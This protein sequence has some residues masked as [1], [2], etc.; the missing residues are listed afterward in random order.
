MTKIPEFQLY[1][2]NDPNIE[3]RIQPNFGLRRW[4]ELKKSEKEIALQELKNRGWIDLDSREILKTIEYLNFHFLR[5]CPGKN[6]HKIKPT[7]SIPDDH[8][9]TRIEAANTDF[10]NI[11][12]Q[13]ETEALVLRMLSKFA[14]CYI[15]KE[16]LNLVK[17]TKSALKRNEY[18]K[19]AFKN[20]DILSNCLNHIFEQF[21]LNVLMTRNG[22]V[23]RQDENIT[24]QIY[25]PTLKVLSDPKWKN[26]SDD[27]SQMFVD[28][29]EK[30]YPEA[31]TK[32]HR[33]IQR[34]FQILVG[35]EGKNS[36]GELANLFKDAR[37]Q[38]LIPINR[39][40]EPIINV[41][42]NYIP[43]ERAAKSTAK[44][45]IAE[46]TSSDALLLMNVVMVFLQHCLQKRN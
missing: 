37:N 2:Q 32:A 23:P 36:K 21:S 24:K 9:F 27:L 38:K 19:K 44:P 30:R 8:N 13:A 35:K 15:D 26:V 42:Q 4:D 10:Q 6:L 5:Q 45:S 34:F 1:G 28:Y 17:I 16:Q 20:F 12:L 25:I 11:F 14:E 29:R 31:V 43:A 41:F 7:P 46:A 18:I 3:Q 33:A 39:F 22:F 40:T